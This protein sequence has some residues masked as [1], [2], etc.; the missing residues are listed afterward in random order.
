MG[1]NL[2]ISVADQL[3]GE[4]IQFDR[5]KRGETLSTAEL[6]QAE[7]YVQRI[8]RHHNVSTLEAIGRGDVNPKSVFQEEYVMREEFDIAAAKGRSHVGGVGN[9][10]RYSNRGAP[11]YRVRPATQPFVK[12]L[13]SKVKTGPSVAEKIEVK[14]V[15]PISSTIGPSSPLG[16]AKTKAKPVMKVKLPPAAAK[17]MA[18][19][20]NAVA[21]ME[22]V[23]KA[24]A[25]ALRPIE[26]SLPRASR[27]AGAARSFG[28]MKFSTKAGIVG[29]VAI[30]GYEL[31]HH[32]DQQNNTQSAVYG[33]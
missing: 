15:K 2:T 14:P 3:P 17:K 11:K 19:A 1:D 10:S 8:G 33:A 30:A 28:K 4:F 20:E 26:S 31:L 21:R 24:A 12:P 22:S 27:L 6:G 25:E 23:N 5:W 13:S 32:R 16:R 18:V 7:D 9:A 29:A